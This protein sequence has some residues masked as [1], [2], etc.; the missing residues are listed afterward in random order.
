MKGG[1]WMKRKVIIEE[2][3]SQEFE[4]DIDDTEDEFVKV[5][6][7]YKNGTLVVDNAS[8][9]QSNV[10]ICDEDGEETDWITIY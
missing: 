2:V 8:L 5:K 1:I 3:I 6:E 4:V 10:M 9:V 7:M